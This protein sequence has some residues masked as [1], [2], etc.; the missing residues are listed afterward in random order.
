MK[1]I[2]LECLQEMEATPI[3]VKETVEV[4]GKEVPI[5]AQKA[6]CPICGAELVNDEVT[7]YNLNLSYKEY[8]KQENL[9]SPEEI[10]AIRQKYSLT[11]VGF[12]KILGLGDKTIARYE[13]GAIQDVAYNSLI[14]L[15]KNPENFNR[16]WNNRK[17]L[18]SNAEQAKCEKALENLLK[19]KIHLKK[20]KGNAIVFS[21]KAT[22]SMDSFFNYK[23]NSTCDNWNLGRRRLA[24]S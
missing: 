5:K 7:E 4:K 15:C 9:L 18:L 3:E 13:T 12:A 6:Y 20:M 10:K 22:Y 2:C 8:R 23:T 17:N 24:N 19:P 21:G 1:W 11:Q 16:L 14:L